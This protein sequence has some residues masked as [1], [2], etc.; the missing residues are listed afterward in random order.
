M[1]EA[2]PGGGGGTGGRGWRAL[3][4]L[5]G[6]V[7]GVQAAAP[8]LPLAP[9][10]SWP[11]PAAALPLRG[12][13][14]SGCW[15]QVC[16]WQFLV[17]VA[18]VCEGTSAHLQACALPQHQICSHQGK[19]GQK[20]KQKLQLSP[21]CSVLDPPTCH[22]H[23]GELLAQQI[24]PAGWVLSRRCPWGHLGRGRQLCL[25]RCSWHLPLR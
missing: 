19:A 24:T 6:S 14:Q 7:P 10:F 13:L 15:S 20:P 5:G 21:V 9:G 17:R 23:Q 2:Y 25:C 1:C 22:Q 11:P 3:R 16:A 8:A 12:H 4:S 18:A